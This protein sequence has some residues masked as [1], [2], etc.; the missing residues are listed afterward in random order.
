MVLRHRKYHSTSSHDSEG[1]WSVV[2]LLLRESSV[3]MDQVWIEL[4]VVGLGVC[5]KLKGDLGRLDW[6]RSCPRLGF[7]WTSNGGT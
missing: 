3:L 6:K 1:K 4:M 5:V 2:G 7:R